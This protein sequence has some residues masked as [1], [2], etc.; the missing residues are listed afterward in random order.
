MIKHQELPRKYVNRKYW[1]NWCEI[2]HIDLDTKKKEKSEHKGL[3]IRS[4]L[5]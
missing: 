3:A 5:T 4:N 2:N 1:K